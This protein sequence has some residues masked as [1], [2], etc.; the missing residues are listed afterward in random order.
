MDI[1]DFFVIPLELTQD[2]NADSPTD[3]NTTAEI[4]DATIVAG[5]IANNAVTGPKILPNANYGLL[6]H[7]FTKEKTLSHI[8]AFA[9]KFSFFS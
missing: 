3:T 9:N 2:R 8:K 4:L 7:E 5:D 1:N 6:V